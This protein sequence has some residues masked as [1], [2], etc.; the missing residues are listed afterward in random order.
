MNKYEFTFYS[1]CPSDT[2]I[3][4]YSVE[5]ESNDVIMAEELTAYCKKFNRGYQEVI[6]DDLFKKFK[7]R[8]TIQATHQGVKITTVRK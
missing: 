7:G 2:D 6:A 3:I 4:L 5:I 8:Q 1:E